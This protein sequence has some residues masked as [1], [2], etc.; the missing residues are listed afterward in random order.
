[1]SPRWSAG[2]RRAF[3]QKARA[4]RDPHPLKA[5][6]S[7][8][9]WC[10]TPADRKAG[11]GSLA[12]SLAPPGAPSPRVRGDGKRETGNPGRPNTKRPGSGALAKWAIYLQAVWCSA[13]ARAIRDRPLRLVQ[14]LDRESR[15][16]LVARHELGAL[17]R[18]NHVVDI[19]ERAAAA[20]VDH[21]EQPERPRAAVAQHH[22]RDRAAQL[23]VVRGERRPA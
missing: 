13:D 2:R 3:A 21:V 20:L 15:R 14:R 10:V 11:E 18:R 8:N 5:Y 4:P 7:R 12:G 19:V 6:G 17:L 1:M 16:G 9:S 22:L 23:L